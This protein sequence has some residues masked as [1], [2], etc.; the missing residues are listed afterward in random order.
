MHHRIG[1][2]SGHV[3]SFSKLPSYQSKACA[4][5]Y[6]YDFGQIHQNVLK[7]MHFVKAL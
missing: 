1:D 5:P 3:H 7:R 4:N 6:K 2:I